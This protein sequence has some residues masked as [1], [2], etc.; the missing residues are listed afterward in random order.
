MRF[1]SLLKN[2]ILEYI[3]SDSEIFYT[4]N[5]NGKS[6]VFY[7]TSHLYDVRKSTQNIRLRDPGLLT[8]ILNEF[9]PVIYDSYYNTKKQFRE[10]ELDDPKKFRMV[11][12]KKINKKRRPQVVLQVEEYIKEKGFIF[13]I[14]TFIDEKDMDHEQL[15]R[16]NKTSAVFEL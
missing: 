7:A 2:V 10:I 4:E 11:V 5:Y 6:F 16:K 3:R 14:I 15:K 1:L 9:V 12:V 13:N 8:I